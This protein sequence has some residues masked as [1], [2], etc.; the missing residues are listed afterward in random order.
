MYPSGQGCA[1]TACV[2]AQGPLY[3]ADSMDSRSASPSFLGSNPQAVVDLVISTTFSLPGCT[4]KA[5]EEATV[6]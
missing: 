6:C 3:P 5:Y 1:Q 2:P 4:L